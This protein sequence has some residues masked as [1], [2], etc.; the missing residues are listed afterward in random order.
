MSNEKRHSSLPNALKTFM[1]FSELVFINIVFFIIFRNILSPGGH[2]LRDFSALYYWMTTMFT[3]C[4][5]VS[6]WLRP[7]SFF[8]RGSRAGSIISNVSI[9]VFYMAALS[10]AFIVLVGR[11]AMF[12]AWRLVLLYTTIL[13]ILT[14]WRFVIRFVIRYLRSHG[15][16]VHR[17]VFVGGQENLAE[18]Y[19]EM[20]NPFYGY[21]VLGYFDDKPSDDYPVG[22]PYLGPVEQV[23]SFLENNDVQ[24]LYCSLPSARSGEILPI[25]SY[26]EHHCIRFFSVP[27][28]RNY[29]KR[30]MQ[31][32]FVGS[33]PVLY[34]YDDPLMSLTNRIIKR[35]FDIVVSGLFMIPF[36]LIIFPIV[37]VLTK[38]SSPGPV[39]FKQKRNGI[40]GAVFYCY[41]FRS[42]KVN[43]EADTVQATENDPRKTKFGDFLRRSSIDELPQ[44]INVLKGDMSVVGPRP[45]MLKHTEEYSALIDKYMIRHW[46]RPGITGWAQVTGARGETRALWQMEDRI[47]K[48][49]WYIE[50]WSLW[51]DLKIIFLTIWNAIAGDRQ[52]Y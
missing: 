10:M 25:I 4:Y 6:V 29:L 21:L 42:M 44:F 46:V 14:G 37:A 26:C 31:I 33:V 3:M 24:Q 7:M 30:K 36:W 45:H 11:S 27:N 41:K 38:M 19:T 40:N 1:Y 12:E 52:A 18:L 51:L 16:N 23:K 17:V 20:R 15:K 47:K 48:D 39:F 35:T 49:I 43:V 13:V 9:S 50:N 32:E 8:Y 34:I 5:V 22:V 2:T 28:V